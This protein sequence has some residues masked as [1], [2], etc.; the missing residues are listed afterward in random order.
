M[1]IRYI[2]DRINGSTANSSDHWCEFQAIDTG[3]T[4]R[5]LNINPTRPNGATWNNSPAKD[6]GNWATDGVVNTA[7]LDGGASHEPLV[8]DLGATYNINYVKIWHYYAD[9]RTY[10]NNKTEVSVDG[11]NWI[12]I[13]DTD[14]S[15]EYAETSS[16]RTTYCYRMESP[17]NKFKYQGQQ[18]DDVCASLYKEV[19]N[20]NATGN[21]YEYGTLN[22]FKRLGYGI[23]EHRALPNITAVDT[24][25]SPAPAWTNKTLVSGA[26]NQPAK[27]YDFLVARA[28]TI[29]ANTGSTIQNSYDN[30]KVVGESWYC[31]DLLNNWGKIW[32]AGVLVLCGCG[33]GGAGGNG[34]WLTN[35]GGGGGGGGAGAYVYYRIKPTTNGNS[36]LS[37]TIG[38]AGRGGGEVSNGSAGG[39]TTLIYNNGLTNNTTIVSLGGGGGGKS[40][41]AGGAGGSS[42]QNGVV[43]SVVVND[44]NIY[45]KILRVW[46]GANGAASADNGNN[47][48]GGGWDTGNLALPS[49]GSATTFRFVYSGGG[50]NG[51]WRDGGGGAASTFS[52]GGNAGS[53]GSGSSGGYGAGGGGGEGANK[54]G[55]NGG[56]GLLAWITR[57]I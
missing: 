50:V 3:G 35:N 25:F 19:D 9:G 11:S 10:H 57:A 27:L 37:V 12:T 28:L 49:N 33:G 7:Y 40:Q 24:D 18:L 4:N 48:T 21:K 16:G 30:L 13:F 8:F 34:Y 41:G 29:N 55:G 32:G 6:S 36:Y 44:S 23:A 52:N 1:N 15:G 43:N 46:N 14:I 2:R 42:P 20:K 5:L 38:E 54:S 22:F 26:D 39:T 31:I 53:D 17:I 45:I 51:D 47:K 56:Q